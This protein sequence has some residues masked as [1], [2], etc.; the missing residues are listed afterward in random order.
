MT[1]CIDDRN[2]EIT[3]LLSGISQTDR[4]DIDDTKPAIAIYDPLRVM[5]RR[6]DQS[7]RLICLMAQ[8]QIE[9]FH[10]PTGC[11]QVRFCNDRFDIRMTK[12][13]PVDIAN[14]SYV[15]IVEIY[16]LNVFD[17]LFHDLI[18]SV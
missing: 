14:S 7:K 13:D 10:H 5:A 18:L 15:R 8:D 17:P 6:S 2:P 3:L 4:F 12:V 11:D 1:I 16:P 9:C